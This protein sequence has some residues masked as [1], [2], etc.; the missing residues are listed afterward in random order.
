[1][2][3]IV[4]NRVNFIWATRCKPL[5]ERITRKDSP[6]ADLV[7]SQQLHRLHES[8]TLNVSAASLSV[9]GNIAEAIQN[10]QADRRE[11]DY[12]WQICVGMY[13]P[14]VVPGVLGVTCD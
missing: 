1:M 5:E 2:F 10:Q 4:A 12:A 7:K 8:T 9:Y 11:C 6:T 13:R 3:G 14:R